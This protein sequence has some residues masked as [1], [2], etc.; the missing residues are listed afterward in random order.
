MRGVDGEEDRARTEKQKQKKTNNGQ[1]P[2]LELTCITTA[3]RRRKL[4]KKKEWRL[5]PN[6]FTFLIRK[7]QATRPLLC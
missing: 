1:L 3:E 7:Q 6:P 2:P 4:K 5:K